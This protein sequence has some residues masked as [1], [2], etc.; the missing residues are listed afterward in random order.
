MS[1]EERDRLWNSEEAEE[2]STEGLSEEERKKREDE[3][4]KKAN[5]E[6]EET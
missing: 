4:L 2:T 5:D 3:A 1:V 6:H